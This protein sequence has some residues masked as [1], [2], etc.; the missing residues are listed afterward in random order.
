MGKNVIVAQSGGPTHV[1]NN[2]LRGILET[3]QSFPDK[4]GTLY[5][6]YHGIEGVPK[7]ELLNLSEASGKNRR[8]N[9]GHAD[10]YTRQTVECCGERSGHAGD[11]HDDH[12]TA[13]FIQGVAGT[14]QNHIELPVTDLHDISKPLTIT[15]GTILIFKPMQHSL[16]RVS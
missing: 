3:C 5:A 11:M 10:D 4:F 6:G 14:R 2:T 15:L 7:E 13:K 8:R 1:I 12:F 16:D 9:R